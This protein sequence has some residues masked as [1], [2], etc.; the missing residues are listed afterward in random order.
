MSLAQHILEHLP[1]MV[2]L[3]DSH[4]QLLYANPPA[5]QCFRLPPGDGFVLRPH[6]RIHPVQK[7]WKDIY[8]ALAE[9]ASLKSLFIHHT[10]Q[11]EDFLE[12]EILPFEENKVLSITRK[13]TEQKKQETRWTQLRLQEDSLMSSDS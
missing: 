3:T 13:I 5:R 2:M 10:T 4:N 6:L 1:D 7:K 9:G 11:G 8:R 12:M